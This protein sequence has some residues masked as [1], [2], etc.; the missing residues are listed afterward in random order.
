VGTCRLTGIALCQILVVLVGTRV[1]DASTDASSDLIDLRIFVD[2]FRVVYRLVFDLGLFGGFDVIATVPPASAWH[3][4]L[5]GGSLGLAGVVV[6][7]GFFNALRALSRTSV[8][9]SRA[10]VGGRSLGGARRRVG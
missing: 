1:V 6:G 10:G 8:L 2:V 4:G 3:D 5:R 9:H 7:Y